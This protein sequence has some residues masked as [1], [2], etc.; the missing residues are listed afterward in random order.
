MAIITAF[1]LQEAHL[2]VCN[3]I[4]QRG[5]AAHADHNGVGTPA[6]EDLG[7]QRTLPKE[8]HLVQPKHSHALLRRIPALQ[9][10][11][12]LQSHNLK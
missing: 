8:L 7:I 6:D 5:G 3:K 1:Q 10:T 9:K 4:A 12:E 2:D 11:P